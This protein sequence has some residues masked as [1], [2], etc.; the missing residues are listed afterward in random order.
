M[1]HRDKTIQTRAAGNSLLAGQPQPDSSKLILT[2]NPIVYDVPT[3]L[4]VIDGQK[5]YEV[6]KR[7]A[8]TGADTSDFVFYC[9]HTGRVYARSRNGSIKLTETEQGA[10]VYIELDGNDEGHR[11]LY[12]DVKAGRLDRMSF[13]FRIA[14]EE[15]DRAINTFIIHRFAKLFDISAVAFPAYDMAHITA[16]CAAV[17]GEHRQGQQVENCNRERVA[18]FA[19]SLTI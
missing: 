1:N 8:L 18:A 13:Q 11:Q 12:N 4:D 10:E 7:G 17:L 3:L 15:F 6:I 14:K 16:R 5:F 2:G 9:E 19:L